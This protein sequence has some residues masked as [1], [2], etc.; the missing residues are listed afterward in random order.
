M[1]L[2]L[3]TCATVTVSV[4]QSTY[5]DA[6][7]GKEDTSVSSILQQSRGHKCSHST[8]PLQQTDSSCI[9]SVVENIA[10]VSVMATM[11]S[12]QRLET[13]ITVMLRNQSKSMGLLVN[14]SRMRAFLIPSDL[15]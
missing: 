1:N 10:F 15:A 9:L 4:V 6:W 2:L 5:H 7:L 8:V 13:M 11:P 3:L 14:M 12:H